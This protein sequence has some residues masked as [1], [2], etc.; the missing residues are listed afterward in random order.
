MPRI[1]AP[2]FSSLLLCAALLGCGRSGGLDD[3]ASSSTAQRIDT[4]RAVLTVLPE[5]YSG[6]GSA[7]GF[8]VREREAGGELL[9]DVSVRDAQSLKGLFLKLEY[10]SARYS[11]GE[12]D[13]HW[14]LAPEDQCLALRLDDGAG[15]AE[16]GEMLVRPQQDG[17]EGASPGFSGDGLLCT[18]HLK[19][20]PARA[21]QRLASQAP[22]GDGASSTLS[23]DGSD[24]TLSWAYRS[25]GDY[26]QNG[27]IA[28]TD[29]TP[30]GIHFIAS[31]SI[32]DEGHFH[33]T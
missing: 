17:P 13:S 10:D 2:L 23:V 26:N 6:G 3:S 32:D 7:A 20:G 1:S 30:I 15:R 29:L 21:A 25:P 9:L 24:G 27:E 19:E 18:L 31:A 12:V 28:V 8:S 16:Y 5:T 14:L 22:L 4:G 11:A 33:H